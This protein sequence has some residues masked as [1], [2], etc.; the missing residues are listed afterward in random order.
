M[1]LSLL[2]P[3]IFSGSLWA[4]LT[5]TNELSHSGAL[6]FASSNLVKIPCDTLLSSSFFNCSLNARD[7][8]QG[9]FCTGMASL[10]SVM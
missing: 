5:M 7:T 9:G 1:D 8:L 6:V 2:D 3:D 4:F 10:D